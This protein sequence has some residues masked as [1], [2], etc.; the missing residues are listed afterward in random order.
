MNIRIALP[1]G[2]LLKNTSALTD[3]A[4]W[5][6]SD[7]F[8]GARLYHLSS[9]RFPNL[10]AKIFQE[11][12]IPVQVAMG[13]YDLG[14][15]GLDWVQELLVK[16][17]SSELVTV[18]DLGYGKKVLY[19][20]TSVNNRRLAGIA[21]GSSTLEDLQSIQDVISIAT[22]YPNLAESLALDCR[23][24]RF[25]IFPVWGAAE[26]YPPENADLVIVS[27]EAQETLNGELVPVVEVL[28]SRAYLIANKASW[29]N[30]DLSGVLETLY[31]SL[32]S[33]AT[34]HPD[35]TLQPRYGTRDPGSYF[36]S[37]AIHLALPDGHAQKHVINILDKAGIPIKDYPSQTGNR[38]PEIDFPGIIVKVV[39]PQD[40]PLQV[41][42]G[43]FDIALTGRDWVKDHLYKFP[44][45]PIT[46][47]LDLKYSR[48]RIVAAI[49][50]DIP[51]D[52]IVGLKR[53]ALEKEIKL[54]VASEYVN[55]A[56]KYARDHHLGLYRI[57]PTW[58]ATESF[59]PDDADLL[60]EN[61]ET[62]GTLKRH[63]LKIIDT[64]FESTTC[65]IANVEALNSEKAGKIKSFAAIL[66]K[67]VEEQ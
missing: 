20:S 40:M 57:I 23:I 25:N 31:K 67:A 52:D 49:H 39:R 62:G 21:D 22:E 7:Y 15:C 61:T 29:E 63:N 47:F 58:G 56:D 66:Q 6:L 48:V 51:A 26:I 16:Y 42:N 50:N 43:K 41:A 44:S 12:D 33:F 65:L 28:D 18:R 9:A 19:L 3:E 11:K 2:R 17:P 14:I 64:L 59:L 4:G 36:S 32:C 55:I 13:N 24:K 45:S 34:T 8:E 27:E 35:D 10:S 53:Y 30:K 38:R 37:N 60:I 46:E 54:R 5:Q 1:K